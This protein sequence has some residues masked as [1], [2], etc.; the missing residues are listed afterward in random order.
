MLIP[1]LTNKF[2][3]LVPL[4]TNNDS[5]FLREGNYIQVVRYMAVKHCQW[6][7]RTSWHFPG[8]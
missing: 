6:R 3:Q 4:L 5:H 1:S 7:K 2:R 8:L